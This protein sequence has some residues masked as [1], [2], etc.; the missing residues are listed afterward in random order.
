M[1]LWA[2]AVTLRHLP[3][4]GKRGREAYSNRIKKREYGG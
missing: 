3:D 4:R 1:Y 2:K